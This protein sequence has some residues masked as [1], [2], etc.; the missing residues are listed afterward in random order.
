[1]NSTSMSSDPAPLHQPQ[2]PQQQQQQQQSRKARPV[3]VQL[4]AAYTCVYDALQQPVAHYEQRNQVAVNPLDAADVDAVVYADLR[5]APAVAPFAS[6]T[7]Q[8]HLSPADYA[9][10]QFMGA[11]QEVQV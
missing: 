2:P 7:S 3:S 1:M 9:V 4:T 6:A 11:G 5:P 8:C 10:L